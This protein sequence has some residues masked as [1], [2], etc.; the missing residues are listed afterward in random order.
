[1]RKSSFLEL[2]SIHMSKSVAEYFVLNEIIKKSL[3]LFIEDSGD[4]VRTIAGCLSRFESFENFRPI[5]IASE[6]DTQ[7][8]FPTMTTDT[9]HVLILLSHMMGTSS[10]CRGQND[11]FSQSLW[12]LLKT[13][14]DCIL[15]TTVQIRSQLLLICAHEIQAIALN[16]NPCINT[17]LLIQSSTIE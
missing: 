8:R 2:N 9:H 5:W 3:Q 6:C 11:L 10:K 4:N 7:I 13:T 15:K 17:H 14:T 1:M 12:I 16:H